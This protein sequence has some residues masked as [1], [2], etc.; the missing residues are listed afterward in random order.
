METITVYK[1]DYADMMES[2]IDMMERDFEMMTELAELKGRIKDLA[3]ME[4]NP[5]F[6][7]KMLK[8]MVDKFNK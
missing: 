4:D 3:D 7:F 2:I 5:E 1:D 8:I 6:V